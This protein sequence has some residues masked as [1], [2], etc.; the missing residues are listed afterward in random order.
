M[1]FKYFL[2]V[3]PCIALLSCS[4]ASAAPEKNDTTGKDG[5]HQTEHPP[6]D[7]QHN[8]HVKKLDEGMQRRRQEK[9]NK[10]LS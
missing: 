8:D 2:I 7:H 6:H 1:P 3:V 10:K 5:V 9:K 4:V